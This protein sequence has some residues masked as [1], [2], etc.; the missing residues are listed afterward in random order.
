MEKYIITQSYQGKFIKMVN[1]CGMYYWSYDKAK[2]I[3]TDIK[4]FC[5]QVKS[6]TEVNKFEEISEHEFMFND[7]VYT[8]K[9]LKTD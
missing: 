4:L 1:D 5:F 8:L 3:F 2:E 9:K 6:D 7:V